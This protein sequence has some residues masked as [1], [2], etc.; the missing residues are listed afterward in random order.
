MSKDTLFFIAWDTHKEFIE[1]AANRSLQK[2]QEGVPKAIVD[3]TW[4]AQLRH[5]RRYAQLMIRGKH[6]SVVVTAIGRDTI[7]YIRVIS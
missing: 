7:A 4:Q 2:R 6:R 1:V 3:I 5:C